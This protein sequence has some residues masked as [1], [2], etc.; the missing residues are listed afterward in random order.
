MHTHTKILRRDLLFQHLHTFVVL[1]VIARVP[2]IDVVPIMLTP[3][4]C[5]GF[6]VLVST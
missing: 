1:M 3:V 2:F 6:P 4:M 5:E